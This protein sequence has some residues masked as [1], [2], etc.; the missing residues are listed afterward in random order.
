MRGAAAISTPGFYS[1]NFDIDDILDDSYRSRDRKRRKVTPDVR[2]NLDMLPRPPAAASIAISDDDSDLSATR[3]TS[4]ARRRP[5]ASSALIRGENETAASTSA[6][7]TRQPSSSSI[8][9]LDLDLAD[10]LKAS[11]EPLK[12]KSW[13]NAAQIRSVDG[14]S[15]PDGGFWSKHDLGCPEVASTAF[16]RTRDEPDFDKVARPSRKVLRRS[17]SFE[18][19]SARRHDVTELAVGAEVA[20]ARYSTTEAKKA[21]RERLKE[22]KRL[23]K[24]RKA[25]EKQKAT[26]IAG[27]NRSRVDKKES[28]KEMSLFLSS[29][30]RNTTLRDHVEA[31]MKELEVEFRV[32]QDEVD[33]SGDEAA[34]GNCFIWRRKVDRVYDKHTDQYNP[35]S[36]SRIE[37]EKHIMIHI[38]GREFALLASRQLET[39]S[40][41]SDDAM[42]ANADIFLRKIRR[43]HESCKPILLIEGLKSFINKNNNARSREFVAAARALAPTAPELTITDAAP[44]SSSLPKARRAKASTDH[45][46]V[47]FTQRHADVLLL[48]MQISHPG[49]LIH[50]TASARDS[51]HQIQLFTT[52]LSLRPAKLNSQSYTDAHAG[53]CMEAGQ[54]KT[55]D[56]RHEVF[57]LMLQQLPRITESMAWGIVQAGYGG[58]RELV[59]GFREIE[60]AQG[61][62]QAKLMLQDVKKAVNKSGDVSNRKLGARVSGR[63]WRAF[64]EANEWVADV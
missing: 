62:H 61:R 40:C 25:Q 12:A 31:V 15:S 48:H 2:G 59:T 1:F 60:R 47:F 20:T 50:Q 37:Q 33:L 53:F 32:L 29:H 30:A 63:L 5:R 42:K 57:V 19:D 6:Q 22:E 64:N 54:I 43:K 3:Y 39:T 41:G 4:A 17:F 11:R 49:L 36:S 23:E 51:A 38:T 35:V 13:K 34:V 58:V 27:V 44:S 10:L 55:A 7:K 28:A 21:E 14:S 9:V 46:L 24:E 16:E 45:D 8:D 26:E 56:T 52:N 18:S